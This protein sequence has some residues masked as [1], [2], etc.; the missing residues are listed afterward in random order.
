MNG[1]ASQDGD[2]DFEHRYIVCNIWKNSVVPWGMGREIVRESVYIK[3]AG[4]LSLPTH[5]TSFA[6][7]HRSRA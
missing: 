3:A 6:A 4:Y 7:F 5:S 1:L 2:I